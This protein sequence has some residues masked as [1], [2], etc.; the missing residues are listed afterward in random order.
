MAKQSKGEWQQL[1]S[2]FMKQKAADPD[3]CQLANGVLYRVLENGTGDKSPMSNSVVTCHYKGSLVDGR[4]F[5][6][7]FDRGCPEA[8]RCRDLIPGFTAALLKMHVGDRWE[9][10]IP[11]DQGY[12]TRN[13]GPIPGCSTLIFEIQLLAI[14]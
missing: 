10:Y 11:H 2:T 12:G 3:V 14:G 1:N 13:S 4:V 9:V 8:F 6:N 5:D 7:S